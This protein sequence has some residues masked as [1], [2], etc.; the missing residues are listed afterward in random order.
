MDAPLSSRRSYFGM[1]L[2]V[3]SST[4]LHLTPS[5]RA[6]QWSQKSYLEAWSVVSLQ[7]NV[8]GLEASR[9][10]DMGPAAFEQIAPWSAE[11]IDGRIVHQL[12]R[13]ALN[14][15]LSSSAVTLKELF[16]HM[17]LLSV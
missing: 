15:H 7:R 13:A 14:T 2:G 4:G 6:E 17:F 12:P 11:L 3:C 1:D 8:F 16:N 9:A 10:L 5:G